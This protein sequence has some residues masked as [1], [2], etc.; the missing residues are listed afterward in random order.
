M[1][2]EQIAKVIARHCGTPKLD[3]T[4]YMQLLMF[5]FATGNNDMHLKN[6][7][8]YRPKECYQLTPAYDLLNVS[9]ANP[10]DKEE[11]A[12]PLSGHKTRLRLEDFVNAGK[13][14][15]LEE[16]VVR[17][18]ATNL[19]KAFPK[20]QKLIHD[21]FL[22]DEMKVSYEKLVMARLSRLQ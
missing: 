5:C 2:Y 8:L 19:H 6:F 3:L 1:C 20:W 22:S 4:N 15:G 17:H 11:M 21:S 9:I 16:G 13:A 18:L 7:S 12:L 10:K 14:M